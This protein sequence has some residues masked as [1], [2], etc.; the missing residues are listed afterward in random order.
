MK[1]Q[2]EQVSDEELRGPGLAGS[3]GVNKGDGWAGMLHGGEGYRKRLIINYLQNLWTFELP[4]CTTNTLILTYAFLHPPP[5]TFVPNKRL[6]TYSTCIRI[7]VRSPN[8]GST[9]V[10]Q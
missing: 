5:S 2:G 10:N 1:S 6:Y 3:F 8:C 7:H 4:F 9:L